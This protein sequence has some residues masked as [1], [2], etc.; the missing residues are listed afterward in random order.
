MAIVLCFEFSTSAVDK[1]ARNAIFRVI[2]T[3]MHREMPL[4]NSYQLA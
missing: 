2:H 4:F 3:F 1:S